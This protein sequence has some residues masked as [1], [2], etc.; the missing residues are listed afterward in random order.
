MSARILAPLLAGLA[1]VVI[2]VVAIGGGGSGGHDVY[3]TVPKATGVLDGQYIRSAGSIVGRVASIK[4]ADHGRAARMKLHLDDEVWPLPQGSTLTLRWGGTINLFNRYISLHRAAAGPAMADD[5]GT[6][7]SSAVKVPVEYGQLLAVFDKQLRGDTKTFLDRGGLAVDAAGGPLHDALGP[8]PGAVAEAD[9]VLT[10]LDDS[11]E[12]VSTLVRSTGQVVNAIDTSSP[13]LGALIQGA[14]TTLSAIAA[15]VGALQSTL[16]RAPVTLRR[17]TATLKRADGT[18]TGVRDVTARLRPG[19]VELRRIAPPLNRVLGTLTDVGPIARQTLATAAASAPDV[20]RFADKL[21]ARAPE[22][23]SIS[24]QAVVALKCIR[25]YSPEIAS[26]GTLWASALSNTD[27]VDNY[28]RA[29][30]TVLLAAGGNAD[31]RTSGQAVKQFPGLKYAFPRPP[32]TQAGQV[33]FQPE[34]GAGP[35]AFDASKDPEA[36]GSYAPGLIGTTTNPTKA[37]R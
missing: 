12:A 25:P 20:T 34:C 9:T 14:G 27:G 22:L 8:A 4:P 19:V 32:G 28:I 21:T 37:G 17:A 26:F 36:R 29:T 18:L 15:N 2:A 5:G 1:V 23:G 33:W 30:P 7:P 6:L 24:K 16:D 13:G 3:V 10:D 35:E 31:T 11:R